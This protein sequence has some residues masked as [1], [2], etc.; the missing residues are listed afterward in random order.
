VQ[1]VGDVVIV[2]AV[3][4]KPFAGSYIFLSNYNTK[5]IVYPVAKIPDPAYGAIAFADDSLMELRYPLGYNFATPEERIYVMHL[6]KWAIENLNLPA[7]ATDNVA[8]ATKFPVTARPGTKFSLLKDVSDRK[9]Y[10]VV[11]EVRKIYTQA[12]FGDVYITDYTTNSLFFDYQQNQVSKDNGQDGDEF[13]YTG[14]NIPKAPWL[15]PYG[16]MTIQVHLY[17]PHNAA[18]VEVGDIVF[19]KNALVRFRNEKYLEATLHEDRSNP[20]RIDVRKIHDPHDERVLALMERREEYHAKE[21]NRATAGVNKP[22]VSKAEKK[23]LKRARNQEAMAASK[24]AKISSTHSAVINSMIGEAMGPNTSSPSLPGLAT[25]KAN[26]WLNENGT[27]SLSLS[28]YD[29]H[30]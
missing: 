12:S 4:N 6:R 26:S 21:G 11:G 29:F 28:R 30:L 16:K 27:L 2:R 14:Q 7:A 15:G 18:V 3:M 23:R 8:V 5:T 10:D 25:V 20:D 9:Y 24:K 19:I 13:G 1:N 22:G 17:P